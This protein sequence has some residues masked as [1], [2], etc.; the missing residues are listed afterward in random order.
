MNLSMINSQRGAADR[1]VALPAAERGLRKVP[2]PRLSYTAAHTARHI[3][4][5]WKALRHQG[6]DLDRWLSAFEALLRRY[7][8]VSEAFLR[9]RTAT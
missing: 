5:E 6:E 9:P 2:Q 7:S 4:R 3:I 1:P 8:T